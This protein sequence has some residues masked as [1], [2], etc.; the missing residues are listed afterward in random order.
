MWRRRIPNLVAGEVEAHYTAAGKPTGLFGERDIVLDRVL[1][2]R[3]HDGDRA[4]RGCGKAG[5]DRCY[6]VRYRQPVE[7]MEPR[8]PANLQVIDV[9][10]SRIDP[11]LERRTLQRFGGL[12]H[13]DRIVE[14]RDVCRLGRT[15]RWGH[16]PER[17]WQVQALLGSELFRGRRP[18][19]AIEV[20]VQLGL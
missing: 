9:L 15:I 6:H 11:E 19:G 18:H 13:G 1:A 8:R 3:A 17:A 4:K 12:Q 20:A 10:G 5:E 14:V 16:Q 2:H 7:Q